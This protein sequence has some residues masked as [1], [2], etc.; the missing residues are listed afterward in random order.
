MTTTLVATAPRRTRYLTA[1]VAI[2]AEQVDHLSVEQRA[3]LARAAAGAAA[4]AARA[5]L[6]RNR[7]PQGVG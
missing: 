7:P 2:D 4:G 5:F 3:Q 1:L 6:D